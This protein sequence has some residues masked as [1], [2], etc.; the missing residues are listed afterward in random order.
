MVCFFWQNASEGLSSLLV[1]AVKMRPF[2]LPSR[3]S[4]GLKGFD[5]ALINS[6]RMKV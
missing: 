5:A 4:A 2:D 6:R 3:T 1:L